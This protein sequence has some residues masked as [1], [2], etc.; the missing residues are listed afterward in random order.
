MKLE[1]QV[2]TI[3]QAKKLHELG[4]KAESY[5]VWA[6]INNEWRLVPKDGDIMYGEHYHAYSCAELGVLLPSYIIEASTQYKLWYWQ[7]KEIIYPSIAIIIH[8]GYGEI[9][10]CGRNETLVIDAKHQYEAHGKAELL[11]RLI[12]SGHVKPEELSLEDKI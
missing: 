11:I 6:K 5:F 10:F 7:E 1:N 2:C 12:E 9:G 8:N 3:E 4:V